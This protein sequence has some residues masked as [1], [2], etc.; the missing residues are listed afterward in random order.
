MGEVLLRGIALGFSSGAYC[1]GICAPAM[2]P[3]LLTFERV[4]VKT[5]L[6]IVAEFLA[7]R[8]GAYLLIGLAAGLGGTQLQTS[9]GG[10]KAIALLI[11]GLALLLIAHGLTRNFPE[12]QVCTAWQRTRLLRRFPLLAGFVLALNL[13]P[14][15]L[16]GF[17]FPLTLGRVGPALAFGAAFFVGTTVF[18]LPLALVGCLGRWQILREA[19]EVAALFAGLWFFAHGLWLFSGR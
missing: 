14:P 1:L 17:A 5:S 13:C 6:R 7:G 8:L 16:L 9:V 4:G 12:W 11:M 19:A 2:L 18:F 15:L 10:Q 3:Y